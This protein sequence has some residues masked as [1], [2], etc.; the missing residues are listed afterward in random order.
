MIVSSIEN[1]AA[2][3]VARIYSWM[4]FTNEARNAKSHHC[5]SLADVF[6][7]VKA[8]RGRING[9]CDSLIFSLHHDGP[10]LA[11]QRLLYSISPGRII[12]S[13]EDMIAFGTSRFSKKHCFYFEKKKNEEDA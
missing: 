6:F 3:I 10:N 4:Y 2:T 1:E 13:V 7:F 8:S 5:S 11:I 9:Q 12:L